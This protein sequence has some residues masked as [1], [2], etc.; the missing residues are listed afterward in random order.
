ME[1]PPP[2]PS[3][4]PQTRTTSGLAI[5]S[6]VA[7]VISL[8]GGLTSIFA[9]IFGHLALSKIRRNPAVEGRGL[10]VAGL[11]LGYSLLAV[12]VVFFA[13]GGL[14]ALSEVTQP[15]GEVLNIH[16]EPETKLIEGDFD[17]GFT[18]TVIVRNKSKERST[19]TVKPW[20]SCS[21]GEWHRSQELVFDG[22]ETKRLTYFFHEPTI[23]ATNIQ[24]GAGVDPE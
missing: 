10:A 1:N 9:I 14:G 13:V 2:L 23:N 7:G 21:E 19:L 24:Y 16:A 22:E 6:L 17:Y 15:H 20:L 5:I 18:V 3:T 4:P 8:C 12:W 11:V